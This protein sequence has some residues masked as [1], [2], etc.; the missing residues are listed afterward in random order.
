MLFFTLSQ[1]AGS[2]GNQLHILGQPY[3]GPHMLRLVNN[4]TRDL[5]NDPAP[6]K[7]SDERAALT[8]N[9]RQL[10]YNPHERPEPEVPS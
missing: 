2:G 4:Y 5:G 10:G 3:E 9:S 6:V 1:I 8:D 7:S